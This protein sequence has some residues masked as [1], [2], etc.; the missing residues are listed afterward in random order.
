M[1]LGVALDNGARKYETPF[2]K[3]HSTMR[4]LIKHKQMECS[5]DDSRSLKVYCVPNF[6]LML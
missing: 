3:S 5:T 4:A 6:A 2:M 1:N